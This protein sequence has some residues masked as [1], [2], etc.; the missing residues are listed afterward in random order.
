MRGDC[1]LCEAGNVTVCKEIG[2]VRAR[3]DV[4]AKT[5]TVPVPTTLIKANPCSAI[6]AGTNIFGG[7]ISAAPAAFVTSSLFP[8]DTMDLA[9]DDQGNPVPFVIPS[10]TEV[11]CG[12]APPAEEAP[13]KEPTPAP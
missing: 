7:S 6:T 13:A 1:A 11:A 2:L 8:L 12:E 3:F 4:A 5:I 10:G 9:T